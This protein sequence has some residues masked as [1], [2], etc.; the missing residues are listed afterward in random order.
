MWLKIY[1]LFCYL[2]F[3][4]T[5]SLMISYV[6]LVFLS[7]RAQKKMSAT[8][9]DDESLKYLM[10][11]SPLLPK[12]SIIAP[13]FNEEVTIIDN[14]N[15]LMQIDYPNYDIII[16]ND[17]ST[18]HTL[19]LLINNYSLVEV[20]FD[21]TMKVPSKPIKRVLQSTDKRYSKLIVVD[22]EHGG[23]KSD[24]SNAGIN[25]CNSK[26]FVCTD[27]DCIIEPMALYRMIWLVIN[28]QLRCGKRAC[29]RACCS[30]Q[31][32]PHVPAIGILAFIYYR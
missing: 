9:P 32:H 25:V 19:E 20:P 27:V 18:D 24:G 8:M 1:Y 26:Y 21:V 5:L 31:Y 12:V 29:R 22:K 10:Q 13:A 7:Y 14:V 28:K 15:S 4:Y 3:G 11:G 2:V 17:A 16:V 30:R 23:R 6:V